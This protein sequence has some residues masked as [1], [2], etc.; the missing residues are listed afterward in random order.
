[1]VVALLTGLIIFGWRPYHR[2]GASDL[3]AVTAT[4]AILGAAVYLTVCLL[5]S[6]IILG[7]VAQV[8]AIAVALTAA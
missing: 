7:L 2:S 6:G 3:S 4:G 1:M 5:S 8:G